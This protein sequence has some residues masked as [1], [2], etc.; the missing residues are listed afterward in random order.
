M[1]VIAGY[2]VVAAVPG[3]TNLTAE[4]LTSDMIMSLATADSHSAQT[5]LAELIKYFAEPSGD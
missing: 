4:M 1:P 3:A 5:T 2:Q